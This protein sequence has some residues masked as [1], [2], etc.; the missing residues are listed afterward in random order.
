MNIKNWRCACNVSHAIYSARLYY[1]ENKKTQ[2][3][4]CLTSSSMGV[5]VSGEG[6]GGGCTSDLISVGKKA[7]IMHTRW[8]NPLSLT[9]PTQCFLQAIWGWGIP[10]NRHVSLHNKQFPPLPQDQISS[11]WSH[12]CLELF[13]AVFNCLLNVLGLP[14]NLTTCLFFPFLY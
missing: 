7:Y 2:S 14:A 1:K 8:I 9:N 3:Y 5:S 12:T 11:C 10:P 6:K 4:K 13:C